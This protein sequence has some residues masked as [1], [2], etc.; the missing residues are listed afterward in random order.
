MLI[1][2]GLCEET[3]NVWYLLGL[4]VN[5][6]RIIIPL[7]LIILG[8]LDLGKAVVNSDEKAVSKAVGTLAKRFV[9]ALIMFFIPTIIS[10]IFSALT[11]INLTS[12]D[13]NVCMQCLTNATGDTPVG[14]QNQSCKAYADALN[15]TGN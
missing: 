7:I 9:G 4:V 5:L 11:T 14:S 13:A 3:A 12:G 6:I 1:A 15:G 2:A 8:M 10:A